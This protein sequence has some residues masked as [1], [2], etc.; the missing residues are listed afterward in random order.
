MHSDGPDRY[1]TNI[2]NLA[3]TGG[4]DPFKI[5]CIHKLSIT[6]RGIHIWVTGHFFW[7]NWSMLLT[8]R[9]QTDIRTQVRQNNTSPALSLGGDPFKI[10]WINK[11]PCSRRGIHICVT[12]IFLDQLVHSMHSEGPDRYSTNTKNL[13]FTRGGDPF[14]ITCIH[15][16]SITRRGI[17]IWVTGHCFWTNWSIQLTVRDQ[18]DIQTQVR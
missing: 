5:I 12:S 11:L 2:K 10:T 17:H 14:K 3:F 6:R 15:K 4:G 8:V 9:D 7:T 1:S 13:A 18:T 16:L